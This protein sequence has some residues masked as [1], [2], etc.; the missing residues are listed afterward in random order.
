L[1]PFQNFFSRVPKTGRIGL[2]ASAVAIL[3]WIFEQL[4]DDPFATVF[5]FS[6]VPFKLTLFASFLFFIPDLS[7]FLWGRFRLASMLA[8]TLVVVTWLAMLA[9]LPLRQTF[10]ET[11]DS[12]NYHWYHDGMAVPH[13]DFPQWK[14]DWNRGRPHVI[15]GAMVLAFYGALMMVC[16]YRRWRL[17]GGA[18]PITLGAYLFLE[19]T[20]L[21]Y[22]LIVWDYDEFLKGIVFDSIS[23]DLHPLV[24]WYPADFSIFL[25]AFAFIFFGLTST[26]M[27]RSSQFLK[28]SS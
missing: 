18:I 5:A 17:V 12:P 13:G 7:R 26:F 9:Y 11:F 21:Y 8:G 14:A 15:E 23:L 19:L 1:K 4:S 22:G 6:T 25:Y 20:P 27:G 2:A 3:L 24:F 10:V 28:E 16:A